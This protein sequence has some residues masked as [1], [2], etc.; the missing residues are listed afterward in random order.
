MINP[1]NIHCL[2]LNYAGVGLG[3]E[4]PL[5]FIKSKNSVCFD[6][7]FVSYPDDCETMWT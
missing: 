3:V 6:G 7:M 4:S 5:Y 2:A 1:E